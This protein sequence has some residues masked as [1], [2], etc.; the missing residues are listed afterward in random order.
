MCI[1]DRSKAVDGRSWGNGEKFIFD[2][3]VTSGD[4]TA[5]DLPG[6]EDAQEAGVYEL[7]P[8]AGTALASGE[9]LNMPIGNVAFSKVGTYVLTLAERPGSAVG[10]AYDTA[11]R[12]VTVEVADDGTGK[13]VATVLD[14]SGA[15]A[16]EQKI[17][18]CIRDRLRTLPRRY[19]RPLLW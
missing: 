1:R 11:P 8:P 16:T 3:A 14:A 7:E 4:A 18:M 6:Q 10:M 17:E 9:P 5:V 15:V 13:L 12:S 2:V 19:A